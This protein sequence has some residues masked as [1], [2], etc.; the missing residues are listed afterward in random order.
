MDD[1]EDIAASGT[2][3]APRS[4]FDAILETLAEVEQSLEHRNE[5]AA[6]LVMMTWGFVASAIF[7]LYAAIEGDAAPLVD[8]IGRQAMSWLWVPPVVLG[9]LITSLLHVRL[10]RMNKAGQTTSL[11]RLLLMTTVP[12]AL[13]V[14]AILSGVG[15]ELIPALW[16]AFLGF[17]YVGRKPMAACTRPD[18]AIGIASFAVAVALVLPLTWAW[19]NL[20]AGIWYLVFLAGTGAMRYHR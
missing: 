15:W 6:A 2:R 5:R 1:P 3:A 7:F 9:Y 11:T 13:V 12:V 8:G 10:G 17:T 18:V 16:V 4:D 19:S 14:A 20:I